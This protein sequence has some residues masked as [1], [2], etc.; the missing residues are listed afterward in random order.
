ML[1]YPFQYK[2]ASSVAD[3]VALLAEGGK[4]LSG[5]HSLIPSMKLRLSSPD[6]LVD[7]GR[8]TELKGI[9]IDG[10]ELVIGAGTTHGDIASSALVKQHL[11][12]FAEGASQI[13][14]PAV[15]N[16][17]TIGGALAHADP[18][19]DWPAMILA[20]DATLVMQS[21]RGSRSVKA[22][23]FF[24]GMFSTALAEDE[25]LTQIRVPVEAGVRMTYLKFAQPASRYALVGCAVAKSATGQVRVAF[26]GVADT[27]FRDTAVEQQLASGQPAGAAASGQPIMSDHYASE[28]YRQHLANVYLGR[29][30]AAIA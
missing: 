13:G 9:T 7:V 25:L 10:N 24:T 11:P 21:A 27:P 17:G 23:E 16:R 26:S 20:A 5:G 6:T 30:L 12:M 8:L 14:D 4:A 28:E 15:R 19:A 3:A 22:S 2:R 29:A 18:S 1:T